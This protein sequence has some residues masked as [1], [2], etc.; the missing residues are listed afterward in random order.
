MVTAFWR[1]SARSRSSSQA[2]R[3]PAIFKLAPGRYILFCNIVEIEEG[4]WESHFNEG[5]RTV[6]IVE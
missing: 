1:S 6:L 2:L 5:M 3:W 4:E